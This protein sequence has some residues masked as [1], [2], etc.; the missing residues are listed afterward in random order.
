MAKLAH[1][2]S[3]VKKYIVIKTVSHPFQALA[4]DYSS[5]IP[6]ALFAMIYHS[7]STSPKVSF[8]IYFF[9]TLPSFLFLKCV[10]FTHY[11][12]SQLELFDKKKKK[13]KRAKFLP[14]ESVINSQCS[15]PLF[16]IY[17]RLSTPPRPSLIAARLNIS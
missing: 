10:C 5:F 17:H 7:D 15:L 6:I 9:T 13:K 1:I 16:Y 3:L 4:S 11:N 8:I 2:Q 14:K 12:S